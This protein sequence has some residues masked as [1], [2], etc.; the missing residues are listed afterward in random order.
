MTSLLN[1]NQLRVFHFVAKYGK[2]K[3]AAEQLMVTQPAI[4]MQIKALEEQ[5]E[6][7]LFKKFK[8]RLELT[9]T[10]LRLF[11]ITEK[12]FDLV[13]KAESIMIKAKGFPEHILDIG[14]TKTLFRTHFIPLVT[15]FQETYPDIQIHIQ[16]GNSEEMVK[17]VLNDR[18]DL[19]VVGRV[20]YSDE[21]E[22]IRLIKGDLFLITPVEHSLSKKTRVSIEE[23]DNETL[24]LKEKGSG[25]RMLVQNV[26]EEKGV[27]PKVT[28]ETGNDEC[29]GELIKSGKGV[30]IM[31]RDALKNELEMG[32]LIGIPLEDEQISFSIDVIYKKKKAL[33]SASHSFI[34]LLSDA[35][36]GPE[37][38]LRGYQS[39][40]S[41]AAGSQSLKKSL[42]CSV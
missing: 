27:F 36:D 17:S 19:A 23:L 35:V 12:I 7:P 41:T 34:K 37:G 30:T 38:L 16:E 4:S 14:V 3:L 32:R 29:I 5:Y 42:E 21:I 8:K 26:L 13:D 9:E 6:A 33:S 39:A 25:T 18:N 15:R 2:F 31:A 24:I 20:K 28:I 10:G 22:F 11:R 1:L 40:Q